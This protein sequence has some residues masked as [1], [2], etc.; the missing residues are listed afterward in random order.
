MGTR[1]FAGLLKEAGP[2]LRTI[3]SNMALDN[4]STYNFYK[5]M[6]LSHEAAMAMM[7]AVRQRVRLGLTNN[8][9]DGVTLTTKVVE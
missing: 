1:L 9:F 7:P 8:T 4:L 2:G 3:K 5:G 6:G